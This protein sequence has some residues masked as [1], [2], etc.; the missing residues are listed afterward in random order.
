MEIAIIRNG[1]RTVNVCEISITVNCD[2]FMSPQKL[3]HNTVEVVS[4]VVVLVI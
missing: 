2:Y 3:E 4:Y 1:I